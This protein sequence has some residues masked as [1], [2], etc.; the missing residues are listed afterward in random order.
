[1]IEIIRTWRG[2]EIKTPRGY[3]QS[4]YNGQYK[5]VL[6]RTYSKKY[7]S[8]EIARKRAAELEKMF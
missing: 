5:F 4:Y 1:M 7:S 3:V 2:Y 6:D 8:L